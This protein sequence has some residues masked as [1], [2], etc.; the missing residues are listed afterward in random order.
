MLVLLFIVDILFVCLFVC[1]G[2]GCVCVCVCVCLF[3]CL[4]DSKI[5]PNTARNKTK[6]FYGVFALV[7]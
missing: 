1:F 6:L 7:S 3:V 4:C 5:N 2:G